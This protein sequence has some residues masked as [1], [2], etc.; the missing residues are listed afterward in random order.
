MFGKTVVSPKIKAFTRAVKKPAT[1]KK[2][3]MKFRVK[4]CGVLVY[5]Y[6]SGISLFYSLQLNVCCWLR[7]LKK[8]VYVVIPIAIRVQFRVTHL[9]PHV[10]FRIA[11]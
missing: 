10:F 3:H 5:Q 8:L 11:Q 6:F 1:I 9:M 2:S 4:L 7:C